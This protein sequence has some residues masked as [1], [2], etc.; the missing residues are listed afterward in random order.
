MLAA[1]ISDQGSPSI[2]RLKLAV[3]NQRRFYVRNSGINEDGDMIGVVGIRCE[4]ERMMK[5]PAL[6]F[7]IVVT[8]L[9]PSQPATAR[10][11]VI[12]S[13]PWIRDRQDG[14]V[15]HEALIPSV[16]FDGRQLPSRFVRDLRRLESAFISA[17]SR[18]SPPGRLLT[19]WR[20]CFRQI[21]M[22]QVIRQSNNRNDSPQLTN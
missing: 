14:L 3:G 18:G 22:P 12:W 13:V 7:A 9:D 2:E 10:G 1:N 5:E 16:T 8:R 20:R 6:S 4:E 19:L 15:A 17:L 21:P 11:S